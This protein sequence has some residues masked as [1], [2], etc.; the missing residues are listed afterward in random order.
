MTS[1]TE[2]IDDVGT[3][4]HFDLDSPGAISAACRDSV[5]RWRIRRVGIAV[6]GLIPD[7]CDVGAPESE[8]GTVLVD[9]SHVLTPLT[10]ARGSGA[11]RT[12][13]WDPQWS[14]SLVSAIVNG[15][16]SQ[17]RKAAVPDWLIDD[18]SCQLC[19]A[20]TGTL[21]HRF[22]CIATLPK[23]GWPSPPQDACNLLSR[24]SEQRKRILATRGLPVLRLPAPLPQGDGSFEWIV[25]PPTDLSRQTK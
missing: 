16:W 19:H 1:F 23:E 22:G 9:F 18:K 15:Q 14:S 17:V 20:A 21:E 12:A 13:L 3:S 7:A 4:W 2:A 25:E 6:P 5:R 8:T 11:H 24:I 10:T